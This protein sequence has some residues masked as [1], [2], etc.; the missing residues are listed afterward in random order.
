MACVVLNKDCRSWFAELHVDMEKIQEISKY[1][2]ALY[3]LWK[4][5]D[6][7]KEMSGILNKVSW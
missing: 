4:T 5:F 3:D 6:D 1:I 7:K 2:L